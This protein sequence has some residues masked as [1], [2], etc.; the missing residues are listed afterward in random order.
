M[1]HKPQ[2][3][4]TPALMPPRKPSLC[5]RR[6]LAALLSFALV[7]C[8]EHVYP[9]MFIKHPHEG[10]YRSSSHIAQISH[11]GDLHNISPNLQQF[12]CIQNPAKVN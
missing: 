5:L 11:A 7:A 1:V 12:I 4:L 10:G 3:R 6:P 8:P 2:G 9:S